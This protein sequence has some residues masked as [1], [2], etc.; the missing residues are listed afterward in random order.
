MLRLRR[1]E[2][3]LLQAQSAAAAI[4]RQVQGPDGNPQGARA[5]RSRLALKARALAQAMTGSS[6]ISDAGKPES[7]IWNALNI[8]RNLQA[9]M[10]AAMKALAVNTPHP[11]EA[12][13]APTQQ[14]AHLGL[15][16]SLAAEQA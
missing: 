8:S 1:K 12:G 13:P 14:P 3:P 6:W 15:E 16:A 11:P 4:P 9:E 5:G 7:P 2:I 10:P